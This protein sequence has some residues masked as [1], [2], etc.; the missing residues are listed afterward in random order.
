MQECKG[1]SE[2]SQLNCRIVRSPERFS[3]LKWLGIQ[4]S[5]WNCLF[6]FRRRN[7][8]K[9][10]GNPL[11]FDGALYRDDRPMA[12]WSAAGQDDH[13]GTSS[14]YGLRNV[15]THFFFELA[16]LRGQPHGD[17]VICDFADLAC[18]E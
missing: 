2:D 17:V 14:H 11:T 6:R 8:D 7:G 5:R 18:G 16:K 9:N 4:S 12:K 15:P 10:R 1:I 3:G 13:V